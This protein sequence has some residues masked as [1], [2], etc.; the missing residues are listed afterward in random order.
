[1]RRAK[2]RPEY[3]RIYIVKVQISLFTTEEAP[4]VLVYS[5]DRHTIFYKGNT[6]PEL[7]A[8]MGGKL[9]AFFEAHI[10]SEGK[11]LLDKKLEEQGW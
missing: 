9:R 7:E 6:S 2:R 1:M 10:N 8:A 4:Q 5:E 11:L 3:R